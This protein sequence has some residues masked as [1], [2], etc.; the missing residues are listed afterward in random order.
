MFKKILISILLITPSLSASEFCGSLFASQKSEVMDAFQKLIN[1][2]LLLQKIEDV[3][4]RYDN[5]SIGE[6]SGA[7]L[8]FNSLL[9]DILFLPSEKAKNESEERILDIAVDN[10]FQDL[11]HISPTQISAKRI[12][13]ENASILH[14]HLMR[15]VGKT[16]PLERVGNVIAL[17]GKKITTNSD[18]VNARK[19]VFDLIDAYRILNHVKS[20]IVRERIEELLL[21]DV[22]YKTLPSP[23]RTLIAQQLVKELML[24][25]FSG[26]EVFMDKYFSNKEKSK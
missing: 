18:Y 16:V 23:E 4:K 7:A 24:P 13:V 2:D 22:R 21:A 26:A 1:D 19:N 12:L 17:S 20:E 5:V 9:R 15:E 8:I 11:V 14:A 6:K 25:D 3:R 10:L